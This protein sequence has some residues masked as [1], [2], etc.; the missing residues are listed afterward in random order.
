MRNSYGF[1]IIIAKPK[2]RGLNENI[3][4]AKIK[5]VISLW[6]SKTQ[7]TPGFDKVVNTGYRY[8]ERT[9]QVHFFLHFPENLYSDVSLKL[10]AR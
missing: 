2:E 4:G 1:E 6:L 3:S 8:P 10:P 9:R 5:I 7:Y